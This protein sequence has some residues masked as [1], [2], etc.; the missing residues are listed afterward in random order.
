MQIR[1]NFARGGPPCR[2][3]GHVEVAPRHSAVVNFARRPTRFHGFRFARRGS[4]G[5]R[6]YRAF[7]PRLPNPRPS[8]LFADLTDPLAR[9]LPHFVAPYL[10]RGSLIRTRG[11]ALSAPS[12]FISL[13]SRYR[14]LPLYLSLSLSSSL[15]FIL[16]PASLLSFSLSVD[17]TAAPRAARA[18]KS[19]RL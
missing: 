10:I 5:D 16:S 15:F 7:L 17:L 18:P 13:D 3:W 19:T 11:R 6:P 4:R 8:S 1:V 2:R 12:L 14:D 9:R